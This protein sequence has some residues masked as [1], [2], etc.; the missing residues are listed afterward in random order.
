V[1]VAEVVVATAVV[2]IVKFA[3]VAPAATVTEAGTVADAELLVRATLSTP[4]GAAELNVTVPVEEFPPTTEVGLKAS[5][6]TVGAV[7]VSVAVALVLFAVAVIVA[8]VFV[9]TAVVVTVNVAVVAP[10]ATVTEAGTVAEVELLL[11][12][13]LRPPV[14]AAELMVT[15]PVDEI[16]PATDV[17]LRAS[18][19]TVAAVMVKVA[20]A[21]V[22]FAV[23]VIVAVVFVATAVVVTVNVP[24]VAPAATVTEAGTVADVELLLRETLRPPVG[25]AELIVTVPVDEFPPTTDVGLKASEDTVGAVMVRVAVLEAEL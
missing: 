11:R 5:E 13:T 23:A 25:A 6:D 7:I 17:G 4:V 16:P 24:V 20:V 18:E 19:D 15:V 2:V 9:A 14:G 22:L 10:A 1:I 12:A 3:V 8:V 21:L